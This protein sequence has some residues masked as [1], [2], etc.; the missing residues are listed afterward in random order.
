M[1]LADAR[2]K[3]GAA[4]APTA[5]GD[6]DVLLSLVDSIEPPALMIG[7][8]DPWLEPGTSCFQN[9]RMVVT[10]VAGRL[11]PGEGV[12]KLEDLVTYVLARLRADGAAWPL[13]SVSGP[14]VF[15]MAKTSYLAARITVRTTIHP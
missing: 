5:D 4:L 12:A 8:G 7:W 2:A 10:A 14:R 9:G 1:N 6:P 3:L 15:V 11:V 13:D